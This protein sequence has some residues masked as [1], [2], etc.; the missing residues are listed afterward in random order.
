MANVFDAIL[1]FIRLYIIFAS[2]VFLVPIFGMEYSHTCFKRVLLASACISALRMHQRLPRVTFSKEFL[3]VLI[4]EDS[5]HYFVY[6][7]LF[8]TSYPLTIALV[9]ITVFAVLH[10]ASYTQKL[11]VAT[12]TNTNTLGATVTQLTSKITIRETQ[13]SILTFIASMEIMVFFVSISMIFM[14]RGSLLIPFFYYRFL[15][16]RYMSNRNPYSR[17]VF[18]QL[19]M[20]VEQT[21]HS[22]SCPAL[23][24][25]AMLFIVSFASKLSPAAMAQ[26][27]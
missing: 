23:A 1:L 4:M 2:F 8:L 15:Q 12:G 26:A 21:A 19:R 10:S 27:S 17:L 18:G 16:L 24:K 22:P 5:F 14:G 13:I 7:V 9:P 6:S 3:R 20:K 11:L 25:K